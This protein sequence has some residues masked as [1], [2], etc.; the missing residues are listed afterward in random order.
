MLPLVGGRFIHLLTKLWVGYGRRR[1]CNLIAAF[2]C[3]TH[4]GSPIYR[5]GAG[6][7]RTCGRSVRQQTHA[8]A[9]WRPHKGERQSRAGGFAPLNT[10][11]WRALATV[12]Q[13]VPPEKN[14]GA[15]GWAHPY[16]HEHDGAGCRAQLARPAPENYRE[17]P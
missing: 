1:A 9:P 8:A 15:A 11:G 5:S 13:M 7:C 6:L 10:G 2:R 12:L 17:T 14:K 3:A 4:L 16:T